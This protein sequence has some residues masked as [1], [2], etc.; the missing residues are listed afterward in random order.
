MKNSDPILSELHQIRRDLLEEYGGDL[1]AYIAEA[2]KRL[3]ASGR[4]IAN[5]KPKKII[6]P[7]LPDK[8]TAEMTAD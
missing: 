8:P 1:A 4:P 5:R 6:F 3:E 2:Q 7:A